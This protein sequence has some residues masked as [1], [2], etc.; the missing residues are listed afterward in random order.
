MSRWRTV[1]R[2]QFVPEGIGTTAFKPT[3]S[4]M[5][6]LVLP[7]RQNAPRFYGCICSSNYNAISGVWYLPL[8]WYLEFVNSLYKIPLDPGGSPEPGKVSEMFL[9]F[10]QPLLEI[11]EDGPANME[12]LRSVVMIAMTCWNLPVMEAQKAA[13]SAASRGMFDTAMALN[14]DSMSKN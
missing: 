14:T 12:A 10:A 3:S 1:P 6:T 11:D 13:E 4:V 9:D 2:C 5:P 7:R 8:S